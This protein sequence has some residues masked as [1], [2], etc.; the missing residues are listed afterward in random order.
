[1]GKKTPGKFQHSSFLNGGRV[2]SAGLIQVQDGVLRSLSPL[3]GHYRTGP[4]Q[5][6][7]F[8]H[9]LSQAGVDLSRCK[10]SK[11]L[12]ALGLMEKYAALRKDTHAIHSNIHSNAREGA[13]NIRH[14]IKSLFVGSGTGT[15]TGASDTPT[16]AGRQE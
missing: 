4:E 15:G 13:E 3:S 5:F 9:A 1:M 8:V 12:V 10:F 7:A 14:G 2:L 16:P 6:R 11:S